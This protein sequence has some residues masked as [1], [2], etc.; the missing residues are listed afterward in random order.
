MLGRGQ[1][2]ETL[3]PDR[4]DEPAVRPDAGTRRLELGLVVVVFLVIAMLLP[5]FGVVLR[6]L[7]G[8]GL[9]VLGVVLA[10]LLLGWAWLLRRGALG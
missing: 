8:F 10:P 4:S 9:S 5:V 6:P 3:E 7:G 2:D 1:S